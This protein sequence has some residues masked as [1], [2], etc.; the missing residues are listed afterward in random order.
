MIRISQRGVGPW[1]IVLLVATGAGLVSFAAPSFPGA[2]KGVYADSQGAESA[3]AQTGEAVAPSRA[4][5]PRPGQ[6]SPLRVSN[7]APVFAAEYATWKLNALT[8]SSG[9]AARESLRALRDR[10]R[11]SA[12]ASPGE[13]GLVDLLTSIEVRLIIAMMGAGD[14]DG[15]AKALAALEAG[16]APGPIAKARRAALLMPEVRALLDRRTDQQARVAERQGLPHSPADAAIDR[17]VREA[18]GRGADDFIRQLGRRATPSLRDLSLAIDGQLPPRGAVDAL[19][20]LMEIDPGQGL[21]VA[22]RMAATQDV[23]IKRRVAVA[24]QN[25]RPLEAASMWRPCPGGADEP[26]SPHV[27]AT[28]TG[29]LA[30]PGVAPSMLRD[31]GVTLYKR[32]WIPK[33]LEGAMPAIL[34]SELGRTEAPHLGSAPM[35]KSALAAPDPEVRSAAVRALRNVGELQAAYA[36]ADDTSLEVRMEVAR[37]L[38]PWTT[39]RQVG[40][41]PAPIDGIRVLPVVDAAYEE[42]ILAIFSAS[43]PKGTTDRACEEAIHAAYR[44]A[45]LDHARSISRETLAQLASIARSPRIIGAVMAYAAIL[46]DVRVHSAARAVLVSLEGM[47][48]ETAGRA[49]ASLLEPLISTPF[50]NAFWASLAGAQSRGLLTDDAALYALN[51]VRRT[52]FRHP[53]RMGDALAWLTERAD[54]AL[55]QAFYFAGSTPPQ[56]PDSVREFAVG[57]GNRFLEPYM[58]AF[59]RLPGADLDQLMP[60]RIRRLSGAMAERMLQDR[61]MTP[62]ARIWLVKTLNSR[63]QHRVSDPAKTT[64]AILD[65]YVAA[66]QTAGSEEN[67][68]YNGIDPALFLTAALAR[69]DFKN[70]LLLDLHVEVESPEHIDAVLE[71]FPPETWTQFG[72][73]PLLKGAISG[74]MRSER[75]DRIELMKALV[76]VDE[77][78][79]I[80]VVEE[81]R[82]KGR[83]Q[84]FELLKVVFDSVRPKTEA[85][86]IALEAATNYL[87]DDAAGLLIELARRPYHLKATRTDI[88]AAVAVIQNWQAAQRRFSEGLGAAAA[89][90]GTIEELIE[91]LEAPGTSVEAKAEA[92]KG[93]G[94]LGADEELP[95]LIKALSNPDE[96]IQEAARRGLEAIDKTDPR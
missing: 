32:G 88:M 52:A 75:P 47:P 78:L 51:H 42:A 57:L 59:G 25:A 6:E 58:Q 77:E 84:D 64:T 8:R 40:T 37:S 66:G 45:T 30:E 48:P 16:A 90:T 34:G 69:P 27:T 81:I 62:E 95:R 96:T 21:E 79:A 89:R 36:L 10:V 70:E 4:A 24:L 65:A 85:W 14:T 22:A 15:V 18:V 46:D 43:A 56:V 28:I 67:L 72:K 17:A 9:S 13:A 49:V 23:L 2:P 5:A 38:G 7:L 61:T 29:L 39:S 1:P 87:S 92:L 31:I 35:L 19:A 54:P 83:P 91:I 86:K 44:L 55:W 80:T 73:R 50:R 53:H 82:C 93:L 3:A 74:I 33:E 41:V 60:M 76:R 26:T 94:R 63:S 71:R 12:E 68:S 11:I 20:S